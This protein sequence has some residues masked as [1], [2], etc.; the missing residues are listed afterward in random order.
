MLPVLYPAHSYIVPVLYTTD[1]EE[2]SDFSII[3]NDLVPEQAQQSLPIASDTDSVLK[4]LE[5]TSIYEALDDVVDSS[6]QSTGVA[7]NP[8]PLSSLRHPRGPSLS[9]AINL[10]ASHGSLQ[11]LDLGSNG[12]TESDIIGRRIKRFAS[13]PLLTSIE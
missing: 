3:S 5:E 11:A 12:S 1:V 4:P 2:A 6:L 7:T 13:T 8:A 9:M 10:A